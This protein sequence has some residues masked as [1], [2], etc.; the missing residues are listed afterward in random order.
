MT[1]KVIDIR[2][3]KPITNVSDR[4][5]AQVSQGGVALRLAVGC[6]VV[7]GT[8]RTHRYRDH[9]VL[10]DLTNAGKRGKSVAKLN[11]EPS[12]T[13]SAAH[14]DAVMEQIALMLESLQSY[15]IA[16]A[17]LGELAA[18]SK[19]FV[20][21]QT[22]E[23]GVDVAPATFAPITIKTEILDLV[24]SYD[25]FTVRCLTDKHNLPTAI[26]GIRGSK[27]S[28]QKFYT[29]VAANLA[30]IEKMSYREVLAGMLKEGIRYHGF[31]AMD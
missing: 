17:V 9:L 28:V 12:Y 31:C 27:K 30:S 26:P 29:W 15:G 6:T 3:G 18:A 20:L 2:T 23:R 10:W 21:R 11:L 22:E 1:T 7:N 25:D 16:A 13:L 5:A 8:L 24:A 14:R 19:Q 4:V